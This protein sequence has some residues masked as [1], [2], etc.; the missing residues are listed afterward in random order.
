MKQVYREINDRDPMS[1]LYLSG[2]PAD[3]SQFGELYVNQI[4]EIFKDTQP[5]KAMIDVQIENTKVMV[6]FRQNT[7]SRRGQSS[8]G[9]DDISLKKNLTPNVVHHVYVSMKL[10]MQ[11]REAL[12]I[13][14]YNAGEAQKLWGQH[15]GAVKRLVFLMFFFL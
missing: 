10:K 6:E 5:N 4:K 11:S 14:V 2:F 15:T 13:M 3:Q 7:Q 9:E 8:V 12:K 1:T